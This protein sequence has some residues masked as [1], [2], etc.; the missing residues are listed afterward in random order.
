MANHFP[1]LEKQ[2]EKQG[3]WLALSVEYAILE[4]MS[5]ELKPRVGHRA[6]FKE[7][8]QTKKGKQMV[9]PGDTIV[10]GRLVHR[11]GPS[12]VYRVLC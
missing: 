11:I 9:F 6:Y 12:M 7:N 1:A 2:E 3:T 10:S 4:L 5:H 8:K